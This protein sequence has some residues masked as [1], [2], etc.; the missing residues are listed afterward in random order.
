MCPCALN[1]KTCS[2]QD[3]R[4]NECESW[5]RLEIILINLS[6]R[7]LLFIALL[8]WYTL[9]ICVATQ[10]HLKPSFACGLSLIM[11]LAF[12]RQKLEPFFSRNPSNQ[13]IVISSRL[14]QSVMLSWDFCSEGNNVWAQ[15]C[16]IYF[17][18]SM[19]NKQVLKQ[20]QWFMGSTAHVIRGAR[21]HICFQQLQ[22]QKSLYQETQNNLGIFLR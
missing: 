4:S 20:R 10:H 21:F 11:N 22:Q 2:C 1:A 15:P 13:D 5:R 8:F 3:H 16:G 12:P 9:V 6:A 14:L 7:L 19:K 18:V 17:P